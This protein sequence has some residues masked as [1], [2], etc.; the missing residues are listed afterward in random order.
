MIKYVINPRRV[1]IVTV[2]NVTQI[3]FVKV[4]NFCTFYI[5]QIYFLSNLIDMANPNIHAN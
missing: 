3:V 1:P 5:L 4:N 2:D